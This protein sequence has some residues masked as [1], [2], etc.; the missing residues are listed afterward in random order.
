[1]KA[2]RKE[3]K[4]K[5]SS[6]KLI[7]ESNLS[8]IFRLIDR[9]APL[10][11]ANIAQKTGLSPTTVSSLVDELIKNGYVMETGA[12]VTNTSGR[13]P[14]MLEVNPD[15]GYVAAVEIDAD[16]FLCVLCGLKCS[17]VAS[18]RVELDDFADIGGKIS[19]V[20]AGLLSDCTIPKKKLLGICIGVPGLIDYQKNI[21][22]S[23]T[24]VPLDKKNNFY[25]SIKQAYGDGPVLVGNESSFCAYAEKQL[26]FKGNVNNLL[27]M[28]VNIG[29]GSG[30]ILNGEIFTGSN[31]M[32]GEIGHM[33]LDINGP[34]CKCGNRGCLE[35]MANI[36]SIIQKIVFGLVSGRETVLSD[37]TGGDINRINIDTVKRGL[38][39]G[40]SLS[41][42]VIRDTARM[43]ASGINSAV[44]LLNPEVVVIGGEITRLGE[45]FMDELSKELALISLNT[46]KDGVSVRYSALE[47]N[48]AVLG[49]AR[50][51]LDS[52]FG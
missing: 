16:G 14:I 35:V 34:K 2:L 18:R 28:D 5:S 26:V 4:N 32:A 38:D 51:M 23:S 6:Q 33:S 44:N 22:I 19:G 3:D 12:G 17:I 8:L 52:I 25:S 15:G 13:K 1:M 50:Y 37:M 9:Y 36:P 24:V 45:V 48:P 41:V 42:E 39:M 43:M 29:I 47:G 10:S 11:R 49:A 21:V 27:F 7:K 31:G 46:G 20:V 30:L 40:D